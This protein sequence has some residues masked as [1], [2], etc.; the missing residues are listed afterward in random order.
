MEFNDL[1]KIEHNY[2]NFIVASKTSH[3]NLGR[4]PNSRYCSTYRWGLRSVL[5]IISGFSTA[6]SRKGRIL[7]KTVTFVCMHV[8]VY[9]YIYIYGGHVESNERLAI[10]ENEQNKNKYNVALLQT[11][12]YF[13]I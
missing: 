8:Y 2:C 6:L 7:L 9:I 13:P 11:Q 1:I 4:R 5:S 10:K 3:S 12:S